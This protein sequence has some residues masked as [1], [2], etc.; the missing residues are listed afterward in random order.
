[1]DDKRRMALSCFR[2]C[3]ENNV[4]ANFTLCPVSNISVDCMYHL[5]LHMWMYLQVVHV[6]WISLNVCQCYICRTIN[7]ASTWKLKMI[8]PLSWSLTCI[9]LVSVFVNDIWLWQLY[10]TYW[11]ALGGHLPLNL[12]WNFLNISISFSIN[13]RNTE[14]FMIV[15]ELHCL[16]EFCKHSEL[17]R[18]SAF[19]L[20]SVC[21]W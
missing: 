5:A 9:W 4:S 18:Q 15:S 6:F 1:M 10:E 14:A 2:Y 16:M 20:T 12:I 7:W 13:N 21:M 19:C 17:Q 11:K 8:Y 3:A